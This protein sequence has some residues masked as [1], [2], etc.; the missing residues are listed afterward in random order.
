M[1]SAADDHGVVMVLATMVVIIIV[2]CYRGA[3]GCS[4][5]CAD[6]G[7]FPA[8]DL[9]ADGTAK[10]A[11]HAATDGRLDGPVPGESARHDGQGRT[12]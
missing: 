11:A 7:T 12:E 6:D 3:D 10:G 1:A 9:G 2:G 4:G 5:G 8:S